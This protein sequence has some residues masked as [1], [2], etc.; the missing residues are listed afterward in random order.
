MNKNA[1]GGNMPQDSARDRPSLREMFSF[2]GATGPL[3]GLLL[4]CVFLSFA[5]DS[6]PYF[7]L[8]KNT[9]AE[10]DGYVVGFEPGTGFPNQRSREQQAGRVL[11]LEPGESVE[12][13]LKLLPLEGTAAVAAARRAI[14]QVQAR[15]RPQLLDQ[16][17][18]DW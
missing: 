1:K 15:E 12:L 3:I 8:W 7:T 11:T 13:R 10:Q 18:S 17:A 5:T 16:P 9:A 4:L 6:L 2:G 14:E